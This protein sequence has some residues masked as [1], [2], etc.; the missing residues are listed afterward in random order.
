MKLPIAIIRASLINR[1]CL[2]RRSSAAVELHRNGLYSIQQF[3]GAFDDPNGSQCTGLDSVDGS[4]VAWHMSYSWAGTP[5]QVK[6][7]PN[8][9][10]KF[11]PVQLLYVKSIPA[12]IDM[13]SSTAKT[14]SLTSRSISSQDRPLM[15]WSSTK[16][17]CGRRPWA[18]PCLC[19]RRAS[20]QDGEHW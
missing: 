2:Q 7:F 15:E 4:T 12:I 16:S 14:P 5:Y 13:T 10:L 20:N 19:L 3:V 18:A 1:R 9:A 6:S 17:W 8:A 11:D